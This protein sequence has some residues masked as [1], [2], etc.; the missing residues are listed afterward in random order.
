MKPAPTTND[1]QTRARELYRRLGPH[2]D[3]A[4]AARLRTARQQALD[5]G[6]SRH[7]GRWMMPVGACAVA[8]LAVVTIW[9]PLHRSTGM[10]P[11]ASEPSTA[12]D[13]LPP[14]A[15]RTDPALY[16]HMEFYAWLA[17]QKTTQSSPGH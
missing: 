17:S 11:A 13:I 1:L 8:L 12:S 14:D 16:Q 10:A 5:A 15:D 3:H 9:Q 2:V 4:T 6:P 7:H